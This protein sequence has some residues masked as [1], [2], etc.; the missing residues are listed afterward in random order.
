MI[1]FG[2]PKPGLTYRDRPAAFGVA[3]RDGQIAL[4][5]ISGAG[6]GAA[7][8]DLPGGAIDAGESETEALAREF[9]EETGLKVR[10]GAL[11]GRAGQ[12][13]IKAD[14]APLNNLCALYAV[15]ILGHDPDA[16]REDDHELVWLDPAEAIAR[17]KHEAHAWGVLRWLRQ[18]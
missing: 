5:R 16:K 18:R 13:F 10:A 12:Y 9:T 7:G 17:L 1:Q 15:E 4:A 8:Y 2:D 6:A 14:G 3:V 11:L